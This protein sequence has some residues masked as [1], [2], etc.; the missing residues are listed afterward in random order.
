MQYL[1]LYGFNFLEVL[2]QDPS[3]PVDHIA[4]PSSQLT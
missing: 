4:K 2:L 1:S 3:L